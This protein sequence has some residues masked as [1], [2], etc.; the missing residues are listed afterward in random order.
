MDLIIKS[1]AEEVKRGRHWWS[2]LEMKWK[3]AFNEAIFGKGPT[4]EPPQ[5]EE[6]ITLLMRADSLRFAGPGAYSPNLTQIPDNLSAIAGLP[7]LTYLSFTDSKLSSLKEIRH[8]V[9]LQSLF[10]YNNELT[11]LDGVE[12]MVNLVSL[13]VQH[14]KIENLEP[15][16]RLTRLKTLY[17]SNNQLT[18]LNG[19]T[20]A[21][22][23]HLRKF[24]V[25]PN[26]T[27]RHREIIRVQNEFGILCQKG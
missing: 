9:K 5:D 19:I 15:V 25:L 13:Y 4:L 16:R 22:E 7:H 26:D 12:N 8:L 24:H 1:P 21:H 20:E 6:L 3:M 14:N 23:Q 17:V 2:G 11:S 18:S 27:L 10:V